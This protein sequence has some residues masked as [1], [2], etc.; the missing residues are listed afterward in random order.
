M[1]KEERELIYKQLNDI[2]DTLVD[3]GKKLIYIK[4]VFSPSPHQGSIVP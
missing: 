1:I 3:I 2:G 4:V